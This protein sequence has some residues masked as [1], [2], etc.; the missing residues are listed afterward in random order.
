MP[1]RHSGSPGRR[2]ELEAAAR[3]RRSRRG[4]VVA[5]VVSALVLLV[6]GCGWIALHASADPHTF[7]ADGISGERPASGDGQNILLIG[8]DSRAG[9]NRRLGG[10]KGTVGRS[11]TTLLLHVYADRRHAVGV[12]IPRD[13]LVDIPPCL[14]PDGRWS[15]PQKSTMF[16][17]AFATGLTADGNPA[18]TQN[19]VEHLTGLRVDHTVVVDFAGFA[20]MTAAVGGVQVC[21][22]QDVYQKDL[23][24]GRATRGALLFHQG[25]QTVSGQRALDYVR[26]RHGIGDGSDI[27]RMKRQQAFLAS[28]FKKVKAKGFDPTVLLPLANAAVR[29][30]TVDSGLGSVPNLLKFALSLKDIDLHNVQFVTAPWRYDGPR[31]AL[32]HPAVDRL[33]A[34][35]RANRPLPAAS[36]APAPHPSTTPAP[37][38]APGAGISVAV[39]NGTT[40]SGLAAQAAAALTT[41]GFTVTRTGNAPGQAPTTTVVEY[42][43]G[44]QAQAAAVARLFPGARLLPVATGYGVRLILGPDYAGHSASA[45]PPE[46]TSPPRSASDSPCDNLS[47][48]GP[49]SGG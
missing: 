34:D 1:G 46:D 30:L 31:V 24:P 41:A 19:T 38:G 49:S 2:E 28:L 17:G 10:G 44:D 27:G 43:E 45:A 16:N 8:S 39:D 42:G 6:S 13:T 33:W 22:P 48:G 3:R 26:I 32:V 4:T 9:A 36:T 47:Y 40:V 21:L 12:S 5:S 23:S 25:L 11:D 29:S 15:A 35:L 37:T 18:C 7:T 14:L 20:A